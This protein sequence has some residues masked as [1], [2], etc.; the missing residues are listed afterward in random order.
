MLHPKSWCYAPGMKSLGDIRRSIPEDCFSISPLRSWETLFRI[1]LFLSL[2]LTLESMTENIL[3]LLPLWFLH[4]QVLVGLF[5]LGHDCGH[6]S[7]SSSRFVN[8]FVG[9]LA[10][11]PLGNGLANWT[12][13][14]NHHHAHTQLRGQD[15]DW[16]KWLMTPDE[17]KASGWKTHFAGKLGYKLPFGVFFWIWLNAILRGVSNSNRE[18]RRSNLLM[19]SVMLAVYGG[20]AWYTGLWGMFK[21]HGIPATIAMFT[22]YFLLTIQHANDETK[23]FTEKSWTGIRGQMEATFDVRFPRILE[24]L[25]LDINIHVPHHVAPGI[26]W[27]NLRKA[28]TVLLENHPELYQERPFSS[29]EW[30]WMVK[31]PYLRHDEANSVYHLVP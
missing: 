16:S 28:R 12:A 27:Y 3:L 11:S 30:R 31:T 8:S 6:R 15:V 19:W 14:H 2:C 18:I 17:F 13:T 24:W 1:A 20:L 9:H 26:P 22:G 5:V 10:F 7:F 29:R 4:G 21:Y 25:W 23:W